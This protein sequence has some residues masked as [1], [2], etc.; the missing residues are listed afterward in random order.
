ME[1]L[2]RDPRTS[3]E[4][5][6]PKEGGEKRQKSEKWQ[7]ENF[8]QEKWAEDE[9]IQKPRVLNELDWAGIEPA[10]IHFPGQ[11]LYH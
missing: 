1:A 3:R 5:E 11:T 7:S 4:Q 8:H 6:R 9:R 2:R 10:T